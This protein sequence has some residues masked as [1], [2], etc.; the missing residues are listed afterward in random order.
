SAGRAPS[1]QGGGRWFEP[2]IAHSPF[3]RAGQ[4]SER[5][6]LRRRGDYR[7]T[8]SVERPAPAEGE[9]ARVGRCAVGGATTTIGDR[10]VDDRGRLP[11]QIRQVARTT[12]GLHVVVE[13]VRHDPLVDQLI[14]KA[15]LGRAGKVRP[16]LT[17]R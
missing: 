10:V 4:R 13:G 8:G 3:E 7:A 1:R 6:H 15:L 14:E 17:R 5:A 9:L 2:S 12:S 16:R 11:A